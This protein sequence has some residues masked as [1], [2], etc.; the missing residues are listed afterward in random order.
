MP[1]PAETKAELRK[2]LRF[3]RASHVAATAAWERDIVFANP[4]SLLLDLV[5]DCPIVA[6]HAAHG[7]EPD[8]AKI[9]AALVA[10][11]HRLA[12][13]RLGD[14]PGGMDFAAYASNDR[15]EATR[16]GLMHPAADAVTLVPDAILCPLVGFDRTMHR[17][18]QGGGYYDRAFA[19]HPKAIRIGVAWSVQEIDA[20]PREPHDM[21][22]DAVLTEREWIVAS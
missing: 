21:P 16:Y 14:N 5:S 6:I 17:L 10:A 7:D 9:G 2:R 13:P 8:I 18:G 1:D 22:L 4:P 12:L 11:G 3:R 20:V 15:L 19:A